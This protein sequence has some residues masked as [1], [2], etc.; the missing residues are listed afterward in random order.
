MAKAP[1]YT[2][3][4]LQKAIEMYL[5]NREAGMPNK[6][7]IA[8]INDEVP[9]GPRSLIAKLSREGVYVTEASQPARKVEGPTKKEMISELRNLGVFPDA[10]IDGLSP[11]SKPAIEALLEYIV[12]FDDYPD[13]SDDTD[14]EPEDQATEQAA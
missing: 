14:E 11:A 9:K 12:T 13:D 2:E 10:V 1:N 4:E 3:T 6:E 5:A 8:A 7:N